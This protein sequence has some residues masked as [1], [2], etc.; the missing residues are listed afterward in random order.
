MSLEMREIHA[1][2]AAS[3]GTT[4]RRSPGDSGPGAATDESRSVGSRPTENFTRNGR[5]FAHRATAYQPVDSSGQTPHPD[6]QGSGLYHGRAPGRTRFDLD[7]A[8]RGHEYGSHMRRRM[9][10]LPRDQTPK[11]QRPPQVRNESTQYMRD[12]GSNRS[13]RAGRDEPPADVDR[14]MATFRGDVRG[15]VAG[16]GSEDRPRG[17]SMNT[18]NSQFVSDDWGQPFGSSEVSDRRTKDERMTEPVDDPV[19]DARMRYAQ[20]RGML[21][22]ALREISEYR[23]V[24]RDRR[25][26]R[27]GRL[28]SM[29]DDAISLL[30]EAGIEKLVTTSDINDLLSCLGR[31]RLLNR[32]EEV[33]EL[34][35]LRGVLRDNRTY[36]L[37]IGALCKAKRIDAAI[38]IFENYVVRAAAQEAMSANGRHQRTNRVYPTIVMYNMLIAGCA[39]TLRLDKAFEFFERMQSPPDNFTPDSYTYCALLDACAKCNNTELALH[40]FDEI[41]RKGSRVDGAVYGALMGA[42]AR[43]GD[44]RLAFAI[45]GLMQRRGLTPSNVIFVYLME[46][47]AADGDYLRGFE[48]LREMSAW[49]RTPNLQIYTSLMN[50]CGRGGQPEYA[51]AVLERMKLQGISPSEASYCVLIEA[52][53]HIRR[54]DRAFGVLRDMRADGVEPRMRTANALLTAC[55]RCRNLQAAHWLYAALRA[56]LYSDRYSQSMQVEDL[57]LKLWAHATS[58]LIELACDAGDYHRAVIT[59]LADAFKLGLMQTASLRSVLRP[60]LNKLRDALFRENPI[61]DA[62]S[63]LQSAFLNL[64]G[65]EDPP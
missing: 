21:S 62:P 63:E 22:L 40:V 37:V 60:S 14:R 64:V 7:T 28:S 36:S 13:L 51:M 31:L 19:E 6:R 25:D 29:L 1:E 58:V 3:G 43:S 47:C 12:A 61:G 17:E 24:Q 41:E 15:P 2:E 55:W 27:I 49:N 4:G 23:S 20:F 56:G 42:V 53:S 32:L 39:R 38:E 54:L 50:A 34:T 44:R 48:L 8:A 10:P 65:S 59:Y 46:V 9:T 35:E 26:P 16:T 5:D 52:W 33:F 30:N 11:N 57:D 45:W 18:E